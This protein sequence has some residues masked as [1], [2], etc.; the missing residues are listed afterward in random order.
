MC[1]C[2]LAVSVPVRGLCELTAG[3]GTVH[4]CAWSV[5]VPSIGTKS[6][7]EGAALPKE[8]VPR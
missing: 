1:K 2:T 3:L 7:R 6:K 4:L 8:A 5:S